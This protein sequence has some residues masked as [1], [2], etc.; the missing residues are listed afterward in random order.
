MKPKPQLSKPEVMN[1]LE[2]LLLIVLKEIRNERQKQPKKK[3]EKVDMWKYPVLLCF[4]FVGCSGAF[5]EG[6]NDGFNK[7][8]RQQQNSSANNNNAYRVKFTRID[9]NM[10]CDEISRAIIKTE[11]CY[12]FLT[13]KEAIMI[14][15]PYRYDN[16]L[17]INNSSTKLNT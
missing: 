5:V 9:D 10:Y 7:S 15:D 16:K 2:E 8:I 11:Y 17:M 3:N 1:Y 14:Y 6:L 13:W 4:L 12:L